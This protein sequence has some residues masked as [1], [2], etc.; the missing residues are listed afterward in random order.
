MKLKKHA[1]MEQGVIEKLIDD[2]I[3]KALK[4]FRWGNYGVF[5]I[6]HEELFEAILSYLD[7]KFSERKVILRKNPMASKKG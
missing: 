2:K 5:S 7:V 1:L 6:S 4:I 3:E